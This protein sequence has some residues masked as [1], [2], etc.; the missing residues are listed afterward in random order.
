ML[1]PCKLLFDCKSYSTTFFVDSEST[2]N[3]IQKIDFEVTWTFP[4]AIL[5]HLFRL[6]AKLLLLGYI[7]YVTILFTAVH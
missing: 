7:A 2:Q 5:I 3:E 6:L 1:L 4:L